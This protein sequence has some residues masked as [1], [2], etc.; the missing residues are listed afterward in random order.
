MLRSWMGGAV[1][2]FNIHGYPSIMLIKG[3]KILEYRGPRTKDGIVDFT[4]RVAGP[5][6]RAL[7]STKLFRRAAGRHSLFFVYIGGK[8]PLKVRFH[9]AA[10]EFV[11]YTYFFSASEEVLPQEM[12][13]QKIPSVAVFK[14]GTYHLYNEEGDGNLSAWVDR[15]RFP[16]YLQMD[17][18]TLYQMG[19]RSKLVAL[20]IVD[21]R[22]P[23]TQS[24]RYKA[25]MESVATEYRDHYNM[26]FQFGYMNGND[27]INGFIM[28]ELPMPS[29][30]V[31]NMSIDGYYLPRRK[32]EKIEDLL[33]F[34]KSIL[35]GRSELLGGNGFLR[36]MKRLYYRAREAIKVSY[37]ANGSL[38]CLF[39]TLPVAVICM[40][41]WGTCTAVKLGDEKA[42]DGRR[43]GT[44]KAKKED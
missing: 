12:R 34:L 36:Q 22:N 14:D 40:I 7:T 32:V 26:N 44:S 18:F 8:S 33:Q 17:S 15:E 21:A 42:A 35:S 4:N 1:T 43:K 28:G 16:S 29:F 9:K 11:T 20:A 5:A 41:V 31:M 13:L 2:E 23:T 3:E 37:T 10:A 38:T 39:I 6:V 24:I 30:I 25:F 27:Y 19:E